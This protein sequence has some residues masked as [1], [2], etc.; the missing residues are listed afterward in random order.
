M[1]RLLLISLLF[2]IQLCAQNKDGVQFIQEAK[3]QELHLSHKVFYEKG[4]LPAR[5]FIVKDYRFDTSKVGYTDPGA[6]IS[7]YVKVKPDQDWSTILTTYFS[8]NLDPSSPNTILIII[9]SFWMQ[10]GLIDE[11]TNKKVVQK[12]WMTN[13][14]M[15]GGS[16]EAALD[17]FLQA[18]SVCMPLFKLEHTFL[19][20]RKF[21]TANLDEW[22]FLPYDSM[23]RRLFQKNIPSNWQ[24]GKTVSSGT[25]RSVY[26][27]RFSKPVLANRSLTRGVY[28]SFADFC[29]NKVSFT[30]FRFQSGKI[31]DE[32]YTGSRDNESLLT[33]YWGFYD[34]TQ[35]FIR[36]GYNAFPA[37]PSGQTWEVY[38][39]KH[40][41]NV[42]SNA[43]PGDLITVNR[44][45][46]FRK[47]LQ[48]NMETGEFY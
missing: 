46:L 14:D 32:L 38:G 30:D 48:L 43:Q 45:T 10:E 24:Q 29:K 37:V 19:N 1:S 35:L 15:R 36:I 41:S 42:H 22:F 40:I 39:A 21:K 20:F 3:L 27:Q 44:M 6:L 26:A 33:E 9:R 28:L 2:S 18:D 5:N 25:I 47:I 34:G 31:T 16:C 11:L 7:H 8:E 17:I 12:E 13:G 23:A 4:K